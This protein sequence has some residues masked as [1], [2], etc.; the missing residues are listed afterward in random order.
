M[1]RDCKSRRTL[2]QT[3][4]ELISKDIWAESNGGPK[5]Q[6]ALSPGQRP[7]FLIKRHNVALKGHKP[8]NQ[9][10]TKF[11]PTW[12]FNPQTHIFRRN[13]HD[14]ILKTEY[15]RHGTTISYDAPSDGLHNPPSYQPPTDLPKMRH[16]LPAKQNAGNMATSFLS[17]DCCCV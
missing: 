15:I 2:L 10:L 14:T 6:P 11:L 1:R 5:G 8:Y 17:S 7:G 13:L 16:S 3:D 9:L 4:T 12:I